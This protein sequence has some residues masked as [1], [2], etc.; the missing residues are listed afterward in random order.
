MK[1]I[2]KMLSKLLVVSFVLSMLMGMT[3]FAAEC[4]G[5]LISSTESEVIAASSTVVGPDGN[6]YSYLGTATRNGAINNPVTASLSTT[7]TASDNYHIVFY[8]PNNNRM[9]LIQGK[10]TAIPVLGGTSQNY[11][12]INNY[13]EI[14]TINLSNLPG[15]GRYR[16]NITVNAIGTSN[17]GDVY[18]RIYQ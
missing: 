4:D 16:V 5:K 1:N 2:R 12:F 11:S 15:S 7:I 14:S 18:Y 9:D 10:V 8:C 3:A 13:N 17:R 6:I